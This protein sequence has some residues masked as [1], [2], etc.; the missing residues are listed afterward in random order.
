MKKVLISKKIMK[1]EA[2]KRM[3]ILR[4]N[5]KVIKEYAENNI[6]NKSDFN[7]GL[8]YWLNKVE[9]EMI[10]KLENKYNFLVYHVIHSYSNLGETYEI[11]YVSQEEDEWI[12]DL[13]DLKDNY[14]ISRV[15]VI[16][17]PEN[18]E[19]GY[20]KVKNCFGGLVRVC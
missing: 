1:E 8:L 14:I 19:F 4:L 3:K 5:N 10:K 16:D 12:Y 20:I 9:R 2:I 11:L 17:N 7:S 18:S 15:E 6:L 13:E